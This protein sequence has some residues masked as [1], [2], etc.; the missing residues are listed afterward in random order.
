MQ[1]KHAKLTWSNLLFPLALV[2]FEFA[3]YICND[4]VQPAMLSVTREFLVDAS[5]APASMTAFLAGGAL[6]A[7]LTGPLSDRIGRRPVL[8]FGVAYFTVMCLATYLVSSIEAFIALR[9]LQ[10]IGLCFINAVGYASLQESFEET[11]A[12]RVTALMA[13]VALIAPLV[14][15]LAGAALIELAPWRSGF[16]FIAALSLLALLGLFF[17]MPETVQPS[18]EKLPLSRMGRD[19]MKVFSHGRFVLS[20][21]CIPLLALPL[22][23]WIALSPVLLVRD[24]GMSTVEY[25]L[26]QIPVFGGLIAGNLALAVIADRWPLGRSALVGMWPIVGGLALMAAGVAFSSVPQYWM[27]A[28]MSL[29]AFGEG[30]AFGVLY[31]FALMSCDKAGRGTISASMSMLSMAGYAVGIELFRQVYQATGLGGYTALALCFSLLY[32][33]LGRKMVGVAMAERAAPTEPQGV[34][35]SQGA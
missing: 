23:G 5:W 12:V 13:N 22:M 20:A 7:W 28:G 26:M 27:V 6:L 1:S 3:V 15:P 8:L 9:L 21:L 2:L 32:V 29:M 11:A 33:M 19:Y 14:G 17:R 16:L 24:L 18:H 31:R 4:M 35:A 34:L 30:M 25:G 10:G